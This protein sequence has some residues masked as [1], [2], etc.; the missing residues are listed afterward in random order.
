MTYEGTLSTRAT[1]V[2]TGGS[3]QK[4]T[5]D[6]LQIRQDTIELAIEKYNFIYNTTVEAGLP[7]VWKEETEDASIY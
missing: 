3:Q 2:A 6:W 1:S 5:D 7:E 4:S